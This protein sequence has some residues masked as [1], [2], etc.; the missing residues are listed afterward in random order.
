MFQLTA[1]GQTGA[2]GPRVW[3]AVEGDSKKEHGHAPIQR[4]WLGEGTALDL[5]GRPENVIQDRVARPVSNMYTSAV[6]VDRIE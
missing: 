6:S 5:K 3:D 2:S 1:A 4:R